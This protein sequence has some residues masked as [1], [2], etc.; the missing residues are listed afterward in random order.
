[1]NSDKINSDMTDKRQDSHK[2]GLVLEGGAMRGMFTCGVLDYWM[3]QGITFD[4]TVG[5]SAGA[6]FG[7][8]LKSGQI[9]RAVRYNKK[10]CRDPRYASFRSLLLTGDMFNEDFC[11]NRLPFELDLWDSK[12][13]AENPMDFYVCASDVETGKPVYYKCGKGG[14]KDVRWF[15]ASASMPLAARIVE[16]NGRKLL[17][18]GVTDSIPIRF[19]QKMG[20]DRNVVILTQP[21]DYVKEKN[22]MM[23][24]VKR[25]Y[26]E[27]PDFVKAMGRRH[28]RYNKTLEYL[29]KEEAAGRVFVVRPPEALG[30]HRVEHHA[31]ELERVYQ[32]GRKAGEASLPELLERGF[33]RRQH[34]P[35]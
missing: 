34:S 2:L 5:T 20:Y 32:I 25:V 35:A 30:I 1:M 31:D 7:C 19:M 24:L 21:K 6:T 22:S 15:Q 8:N 3:E 12:A 23:P 11:Y 9:G 26:R 18:G 4:G 16:I 29:E 10:Y 33:C 13:F 14:R 17:D 27:Y 28:L